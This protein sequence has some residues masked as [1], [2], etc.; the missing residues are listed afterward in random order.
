MRWPSWGGTILSRVGL[1]LGGFLALV[2]ALVAPW[3]RGAVAPSALETA[4]LH[5]ET[6]LRSLG[7]LESPAGGPAATEPDGS[8]VLERGQTLGGVLSDLGLS[9]PEVHAVA[10]AARS[11]VD[12]R[13]LRPGARWSVFR[14]DRGD[15]E[16]FD[17][18]LT[19]R[20][21]LTVAR[22]AVAGGD[23]PTWIPSF[24]E[25]RRETRVRTVSGSLD[26]SLEESIERAGGDAVLAYAMAD[27]LQWDLDFS[28]DLRTG[29]EFRVLFEETWIEGSYRGLGRILA[30][31]YGH[32]GGP[33]WSAYRF[34]D[35]GFYDAEG[36]P[37]QKMFLRAPVPFT[38]ITSRFSNR[39]FHPILHV[40]RPHH[41]VDYGAP[42]GTPV[43]V[44]ASGSVVF[45]GWDGGGGRVIKVRHPNDY[46]T[47]YMHLSRFAAGIRPGVRVHQ[48]DLIGYVG[49]TGLATASHL[50]YRVQHHGAWIDPLR[51]T[52]VPAEPLSR[53]LQAD[54]Q[55]VRAEM[56]ASLVSGRPYLPPSAGG[57]VEPT[58][59]AT[60]DAAARARK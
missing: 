46:L 9:A 54:F 57:G 20:G 44:T 40:F 47:C 38:R 60:A 1:P 25:Y 4:A 8:G 29:D 21:E 52:S 14:D 30:L 34:R 45:A 37:L 43:R 32:V 58:R 48:G 31:S 16:R 33:S 11:Y 18:A 49:S 42:T 50:D 41:G 23:D 22:T 5:P 3:D 59:V 51:I 24:R 10:E 2:V 53:S 35:Q 36:R 26:G 56:D 13:Q 27:V 39:R 19:E 28:R 55:A 17:L 6:T 12:P 7:G 15:L